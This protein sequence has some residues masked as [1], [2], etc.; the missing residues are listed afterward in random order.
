MAK[1]LTK[2]EQIQKDMRTIRKAKEGIEQLEKI[3]SDI[4]EDYQTAMTEAGITEVSSELGV[5]QR[6]VSSVKT[7]Y[8]YAKYVK[9]KGIVLDDLLPYAKTSSSKSYVRFNPAKGVKE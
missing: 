7:K 3:V 9:D 5:L 1:D 8:D 4:L 6:V 2:Q